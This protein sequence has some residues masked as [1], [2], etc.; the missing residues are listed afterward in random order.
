MRAVAVPRRGLHKEDNPM[1]ISADR[2]GAV[3]RRSHTS[4]SGPGDRAG[5]APG[6]RPR[7]CRGPRLGLLL[8]ACLLGSMALPRAA[9]AASI[10]NPDNGHYYEAVARAAGI[11]WN[12][13]NAAAN[14]RTYQ[15]MHG[16]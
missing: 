15:G 1:R 14:A 3:I 13:A 10:M 12:A 5:P 4:C 7:R 2:C 8:G 9:G 11:S 6:D 16:H